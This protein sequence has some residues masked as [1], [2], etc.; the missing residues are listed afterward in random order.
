MIRRTSA[1]PPV[2][3]VTLPIRPPAAITGWFSRTPS[4][5][6][7]SILTVEYQ[8]VADFAITRAFTG[9]VDCGK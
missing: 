5:E 3:V 6:P 9:A 2:T 4:S 7:L 1:V 8:T